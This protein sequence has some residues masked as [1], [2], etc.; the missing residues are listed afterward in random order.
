MRQSWLQLYPGTE[1]IEMPACGHYAMHEAPVAL[2][3]HI[4]SFLAQH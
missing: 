2:V 1:L 3:N 4:E